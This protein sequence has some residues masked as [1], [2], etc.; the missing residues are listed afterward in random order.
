ME[1]TLLSPVMLWRDFNATEPLKETII[2]NETYRDFV[3]SDVYFSGRETSDGRVRVYGIL[4]KNRLAGK[5]ANRSAILIL[6]DADQSVNLETINIYVE[7][8][9]TVLMIDYRGEWDG[10]DNYTKYP[11]SV[12]YANYKKA[13][14]AIGEELHGTETCE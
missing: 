8:G 13:I 6:P 1:T 12:A 4:A 10:V 14:E 3:Y 11:E 2:G 7:Q 9:Y 5:K